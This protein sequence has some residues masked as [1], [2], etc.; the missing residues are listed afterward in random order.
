MLRRYARLRRGA[1]LRRAHARQH[2]LLHDAPLQVGSRS[3]QPADGREI[4]AALAQLAEDA[5]AAP[6]GSSPSPRARDSAATSGW[7][8]LKWMYQIR[9]AK[10]FRPI[11]ADRRRSRR[12]EGV[13]AGVE[14]QAQQVGI[15]QVHAAGRSRPASRRSRRSGDGRR[16]AGRSR[17]ARRAP[18]CSAPAAKACHS[19]SLSPISGVTRPAFFVRTG[20]LPL[21]SARTRKGR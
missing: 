8:S 19:R 16:C 10:R 1:F 2:I 13:V 5:V 4:D 18:P 20:S 17:R 3:S 9:S 7:Q 11:A 21:L 14:D 6:T 15:G 12:A